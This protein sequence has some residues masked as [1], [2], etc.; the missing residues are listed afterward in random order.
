MIKD[1]PL[2]GV[3]LGS[4]V[5]ALPSYIDSKPREAHNTFIQ[6]AAESGVG[7]GLCYLAIIGTFLKNSRY[8]YR[9]FKQQPSDDSFY[10]LLNAASSISFLGLVV[11]SLFLSLNRYEIFFYLVIINNSLMTVRSRTAVLD[12]SE[13][14]PDGRAQAGPLPW[15]RE[16]SEI[17]A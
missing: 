5:T 6:F 13:A 14:C 16:N 12:P 3:G 9:T 17:T 11:C 8:I 7:A 1:H 4:F 2:S 10:Q 15:T